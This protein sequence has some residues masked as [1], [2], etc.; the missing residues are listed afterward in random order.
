[1]K[2]DGE[3]P[4]SCHDNQTV[5]YQ[6][7]VIHIGGYNRDQRRRSKM[8]NELQLTSPCTMK[9]LCQMPE[10]R[11][12]HGAEIFEDKVVILGG[13]GGKGHLNTVLE[14]DVN[15]NE[16][17]KMSPLP[18][19]L[20]N[21]A[22]VCWRDQVVVLGGYNEREKASNDVFMYD[23]HTGKTTRPC[24]RRDKDAVQLLL[25]TPL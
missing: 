11:S 19:P 18:H 3:L 16:C 9:K 14:F 15:K 8:I 23:C 20:S 6:Q 4:Y 25:E 2:Y 7:R 5:V 22:T 17:K 12:C 13:E 24:S 10:P 1:M 21:M